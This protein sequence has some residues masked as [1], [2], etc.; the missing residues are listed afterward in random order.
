MTAGTA[1]F[2]TS[3]AHRAAD[4]P[5]KF[6]ST[7]LQ[8]RVVTFPSRKGPAMILIAGM[9]G[10]LRGGVERIGGGDHYGIAVHQTLHK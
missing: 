3:M 2:T 6:I 9:E 7:S 8:Q 5:R 4:T 10:E 1:A